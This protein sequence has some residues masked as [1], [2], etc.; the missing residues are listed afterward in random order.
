MVLKMDTPTKPKKVV[1]KIESPSCVAHPPP[2]LQRSGSISGLTSM[3]K[4][5]VAHEDLFDAMRNQFVEQQTIIISQTEALS[6]SRK[7]IAEQ[8]VLLDELTTALGD[9]I[10]G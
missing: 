1:I 2:R 8:Q 9:V 10:N 3:A 4:S 5:L 6:E 7:M